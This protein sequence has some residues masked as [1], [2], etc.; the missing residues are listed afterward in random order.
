MDGSSGYQAIASEFLR[1]RSRGIGVQ[2]VRSWART[3]PRG[4]SVIDLGCGPGFPITSV[5]V[6][7]NLDVFGV[8]AA[9]SLVDAF[10]QNLPGTPILC[11]AVQTS[12]LFHRSFDAV[13][14]LGLMFL[15]EAEDQY[16]LIQRI[17]EILVP[18][19]RLLFTSPAD[20]VVWRDAMTGM[21]SVSLGAEKYRALLGTAGIS[22]K[23]EYQDEGQNYYFDAYRG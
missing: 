4:S 20:A 10:K 12:S 21:Q 8:D 6:D 14:A 5:L 1:H 19:G 22:V 9:P 15:L 2:E 23:S 17:A 11:E 16:R 7:E 13:L 18:N 3:L